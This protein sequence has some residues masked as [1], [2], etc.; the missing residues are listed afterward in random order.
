MSVSEA[1][2]PEIESGCSV[3]SRRRPSLKNDELLEKAFEV[4]LDLGFERASIDAI[5]ISVGIAKR[6]LY[7]RY[8]DKETLF[9]AATEHAIERWILPVERLREAEQDDL[10]ETLLAIGRLLVDNLLSPDGLRLL[11]LTNSVSAHMPEIG[12][13]NVRQGINPTIAFLADLLGRRIGP[14]LRCF[15]GT[16]GAALAFINL[17]VSG[18]AN[19]TAWGV[20]LDREFVDRYVASSVCLFVHGLSPGPTDEGLAKLEHEARR[21]KLLL[22]DTMIQLDT[23]RQDLAAARDGGASSSSRPL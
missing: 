14:D 17:V 10:Q 23:A 12:A 18:P 4:F 7:L 22:A 2:D 13:H 16:R 8:G 19:L 5:S 3:R 6:T 20:L 21:L 9:R 11:Q 1:K 15:S